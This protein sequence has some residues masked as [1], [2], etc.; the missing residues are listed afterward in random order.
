MVRKVVISSLH[1]LLLV[2]LHLVYFN[3]NWSLPLEYEMMM[4]LNKLETHIGGQGKFNEKNYLFINTA[5]NAELIDIETEYGEEGKVTIVDRELLGRF[6]KKINEFGNDHRFILCDILFNI[7]TENDSLL[8]KNISE[9]KN[10]VIPAEYDKEQEHI[11]EPIFQV[12]NAQA[13]YITYE[14]VV[15]KIRLFA[16]ESRRKTLPLLMYEKFNGLSTHVNSLGL[17]YKRNYIPRSIYPRYY[18]D[19]ERMRNYEMSLGNLVEVLNVSDTLFYN[20]VI[21]G[22]ILVIGNFTNDIHP[23]FVGY[24][25]GSLILLNTFLTLEDGY[26]LLNWTWFI[27]IIICFTI[28]SYFEFFKHEKEA[29]EENVNIKKLLKNILNVALW[30]LVISFL[31]GLIFKIH[32]TVILLIV[33]VELFRHVGKIKWFMVKN[34]K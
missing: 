15:S 27:F 2:L 25:P 22:K 7:R 21:K 17:T 28:L 1:A 30:C 20:E 5:Y 18:F 11:L 31:S 13:D 6:F 9:I 16:E 3:L 33:Y 12:S 8:E 4:K 34:K 23:T 26:H 19:R 32:T 29:A 24:L 14:G 10:L